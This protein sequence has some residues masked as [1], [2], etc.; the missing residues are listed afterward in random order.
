[1]CSVEELAPGA[2]RSVADSVYLLSDFGSQVMTVLPDDVIADRTDDWMR[3]V[4]SEAG[5]AALDNTARG[6]GTHAGGNRARGGIA[7][8]SGAAVSAGAAGDSAPSAAA[9]NLLCCRRQVVVRSFRI[10][11]PVRLHE[12]LCAAFHVSHVEPGVVGRWYGVRCVVAAAPDLG[13]EDL[14][15]CVTPLTTSDDDY[16]SSYAVSVVSWTAPPGGASCPDDVY[17]RAGRQWVCMQAV[18]TAL[19]SVSSGTLPRHDVVCPACVLCGALSESRRGRCCTFDASRVVVLVSRGV[20]GWRGGCALQHE[21][22]RDMAVA[23]LLPRE[24]LQVFEGG[25]DSGGPGADANDTVVTLQCPGGVVIRNFRVPRVDP[26]SYDD[27]MATLCDSVR[28]QLRLPSDT[29]VPTRLRLT[30]FPGRCFKCFT[31]MIACACLQ[32]CA[33]FPCTDVNCCYCCYPCRSRCVW[34]WTVCRWISCFPVKSST[35]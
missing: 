31:V 23:M 15:F 12:E 13:P 28:A 14:A 3:Y 10:R 17:T 1:M 29:Q 5:D 27:P 9:A 26:D 19:Q 2:L 30:G 7:V 21:V 22:T 24:Y 25:S 8:G 16:M 11:D 6:I 32:Q 18:V 34:T 4:S 35:A 33:L 20:A